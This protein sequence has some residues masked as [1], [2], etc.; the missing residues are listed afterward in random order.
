M[1][2]LTAT[3]A[4]LLVTAG[5]IMLSATPSQAITAIVPNYFYCNS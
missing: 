1:K 2:K 3:A 4:A 5:G